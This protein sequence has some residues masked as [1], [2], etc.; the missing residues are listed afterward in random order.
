M[1]NSSKQ[2]HLA[3]HPKLPLRERYGAVLKV[4]GFK[5]PFLTSQLNEKE[6]PIQTP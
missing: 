1:G 3:T 2:G 5:T 6:V 4:I